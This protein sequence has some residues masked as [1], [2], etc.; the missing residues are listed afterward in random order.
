MTN[1]HGVAEFAA[2]L[3]ALGPMGLGI[4]GAIALVGLVMWNMDDGNGIKV[5]VAQNGRNFLPVGCFSLSAAQEAV[6]ADS[7]RF[8]LDPRKLFSL[9]L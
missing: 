9:E 7:D 6:I 8:F 4:G 1:G 3:V 5:N 2:A